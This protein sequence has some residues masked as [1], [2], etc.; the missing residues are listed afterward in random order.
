MDVGKCESCYELDNCSSC[1]NCYFC[2][3]GYQCI[4]SYF[5]YSCYNCQNCF[6]CANL[7]HK[8]YCFLNQ[9]LL[10]EEYQQKIKEINL[11]NRDV[12]KKYQEKFEKFF[13]NAIR[14]NLNVDRKNIN[15]LGDRLW[16]AKNCY[17]VFR[18]AHEIENVRYADDLIWHTKDSMDVWVVGPNISLSYE[19]IES[20][21]SSNLKFS[22]FIHNGL[23]LEYCLECHNCYNCFGCIGLRNKKYHIFNK[24]YSE[25]NYWKELDKI[26]TK[27]LKDKEYGEFFPLSMSLHSYNNTYAMI[28]FPLTKE[29]VLKNGWQW[30]DEPKIPADLMGLELIEAKDVSQDIK[31]VSD[32]ILEKAIIC[33]IT[34]KPFRI[35]EPELEFY[36]KHNLPILTK[37][38]FQRMLEKFQK[39]N[40]SKLWKGVCAKCGTQMHTS[41]TPEKQKELNIYCESCYIK[42]IV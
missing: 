2:V 3:D 16:G 26:K 35:I 29:Q 27:I 38:P 17:L 18:T 39:R 24:S 19:V 31:D 8:S 32:N 13:K 40:P 23:D 41:Y 25:E 21:E 22:F 15:C 10:K 7:R 30:H 12:L 6:G 4:D 1:Y 20:Y 28:E 9:Q 36:Q 14:K 5:L 34:G 42:E 11:G 33:E 37:H